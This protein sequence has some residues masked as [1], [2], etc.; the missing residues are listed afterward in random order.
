MINGVRVIGNEYQPSSYEKFQRNNDMIEALKILSNKLVEMTTDSNC[1]IDYVVSNK[2]GILESAEYNDLFPLVDENLFV[3]PFDSYDDDFKEFAEMFRE[4]GY[5]QEVPY[6]SG[7][8]V[9]P[10]TTDFGHYPI[11]LITSRDGMPLETFRDI[12]YIGPEA[13]YERPAEEI[14]IGG[15]TL[16][17]E[18][19]RRVRK[20]DALSYIN[21]G[22]DP[23]EFK[24]KD[25]NGIVYKSYSIS[26]N[27][28]TLID[29]NDEL[30]CNSS[31]SGDGPKQY[32]KKS[33]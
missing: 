21:N 16:S 32:E 22:G 5:L 27:D 6:Y 23:K 9:A 4:K 11:V 12:A 26:G 1:P 17:G 19:L 20:I 13:I 15:G 2:S 33:N 8:R 7:G 14:I 30:H 28:Y 18:A 31:V 29:Y 25:Y 10:F 24:L 3:N